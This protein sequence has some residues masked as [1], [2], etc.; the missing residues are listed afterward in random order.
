M[1]RLLILLLVAALAS[2]LVP[3]AAHGRPLPARSERTRARSG[4]EIS[5]GR[6]KRRLRFGDFFSRM[7]LE[8][9][10]RPRS[11]PLAVLRKRFFEPE[12]V[13]IFGTA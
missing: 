7:W 11:F 12:C 10:R 6:E 3:G 1:N 9:A 2:D 5:T 4:R 8:Y 13:F